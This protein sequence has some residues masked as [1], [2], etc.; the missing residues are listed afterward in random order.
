MSASSNDTEVAD[1]IISALRGLVSKPE[2]YLIRA[3]QSTTLR[4]L[5]SAR[6]LL[7]D[8]NTASK[9]QLDVQLADIDQAA[10][11]LTSIREDLDHI[12]ARLRAMQQQLAVDQPHLYEQFL[13]AQ[14]AQH[15]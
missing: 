13:L 4:Q 3:A 5:K 14:E 10:Q 9:H 15:S 2:L 1:A 7:R 12:Y 6:K 8:F 11:L